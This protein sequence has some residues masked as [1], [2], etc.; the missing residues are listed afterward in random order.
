MI[1]SSSMTTNDNNHFN[2]TTSMENNVDNIKSLDDKHIVTAEND[3]NKF[4]RSDAWYDS[5]CSKKQ[6]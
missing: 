6:Q 5:Y 2:M 1:V 3:N 4:S